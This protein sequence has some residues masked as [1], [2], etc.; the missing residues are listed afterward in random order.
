M[1]R[2]ICEYF[3]IFIL[4]SV[5]GWIMETLLFIF[6]DKQIVKRGFLYGPLCPIYGS[7]AIICTLIFYGRVDN[8][9]L[10]FLL[11]SLVCGFLEYVTHFVLEKLF[12]A[13]W[14]DY[15]CRRFNLNGRIYLNGVLL[16][17]LGSVIIVKLI[18][19]WMFKLT[20]IMSNTVL[21]SVCFVLYSILL[22]DFAITLAKLMDLVKK[23]HDLQNS[24]G[25]TV[26]KG[27]D[28][29]Q[30]LVNEAVD[31]IK[32]SKPFN[33]AA[34]FLSISRVVLHIKPSSGK[35]RKIIKK[36]IDIIVDKPVKEGRTD[37][38]YYGDADKNKK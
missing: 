11:G 8:I 31:D 7:G 36:Y 12:N 4:Y 17:G 13:M 26:Q 25:E 21:Y 34:K 22:F 28:D 9:F 1:L 35:K 10:L 14:W 29:S 16:F 5:A 33:D 19:P 24:L 6:R 15:S 3:L 20:D 37:I 2:N 38:K 30:R 18:Q 32:N 27:I 23:M